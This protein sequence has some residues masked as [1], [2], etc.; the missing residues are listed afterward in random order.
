MISDNTTDVQLKKVAIQGGEGAFHEIAARNY[1]KSD[2]QILPC[3]TFENITTLIENREI[4]FGIMA[5][6]NTVAGSIIPNYVL[7]KESPVKII[8]EEYLRIKQNLVALP[9]QKIEEL[10]EV[11]SHYMAIAQSRKFFK[12]FPDIKLVE[13][14]DTALSAKKIQDKRLVGKGAI[15]SELA[16]KMYGLDILAPSI[17]TN[18]RNYTRFL[19]LTHKDN[20]DNKPENINKASLCFSL[21]HQTGSLSQ[22]LSVFAFYN[23][24][25]TKIQSMPIVGKEFQY[26][27]YVDLTFDSCERYKQSLTAIKPLVVDLQILGEYKYGLESLENIHQQ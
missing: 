21:Q 7:I 18:K 2:I 1:F 3:K 4:D 17:E 15:A 27:F 8:G 13:S 22:I 23:L 19:I 9:G 12:N 24:D 14:V 6:E 25:L 16:A 11:H 26:F 10:T 20:K 5:I